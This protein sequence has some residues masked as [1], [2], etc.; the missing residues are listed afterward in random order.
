MSTIEII[1]SIILAINIGTS[2]YLFIKIKDLNSNFNKLI[3][4]V[5]SG[6]FKDILIQHLD[7]IDKNTDLSSRIKKDLETFKEFTDRNLQKVGFKRFNPFHETGGDQSF[8]LALLDNNNNGVI[9]SSLHQRENTR[10]YAKSIE[11]GEC[12]NKLSKE[13]KEVLS[14]TLNK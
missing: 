13:E 8:I 14:S 6:N 12:K 4:G 7:R 11:K 3:K 1:L 10:I 9:L 2:T 5:K